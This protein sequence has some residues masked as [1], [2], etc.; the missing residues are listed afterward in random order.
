MADKF[1]KNVPLDSDGDLDTDAQSLYYI[2]GAPSVEQELRVRLNTIEGEDPFHPEFGLPIFEMAGAPE[3]VVE[4]EIRVE[5]RRDDRVAAVPEIDI[6][7]PQGSRSA[8]IDV[9]VQLVDGE[10]IAI[11][12]TL[13][14]GTGLQ[15]E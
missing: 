1:Q 14:D 2:N 4:R 7:R 13:P 3:A 10:P 8:D 6:E 12:T 9:T 5:L 15:A 11:T